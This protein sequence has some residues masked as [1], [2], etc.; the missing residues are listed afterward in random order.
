MSYK[1]N[2]NINGSISG[3]M[4]FGNHSINM[5]I[6]EENNIVQSDDNKIEKSVIR[7]NENNLSELKKNTFSSNLVKIII[8]IIIGVIIS[9]IGG[10]ILYKLN[11]N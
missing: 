7:N 1:R 8:E 4:N 10:Y 9:V 2:I 6:N 5:N 11:M 3:I